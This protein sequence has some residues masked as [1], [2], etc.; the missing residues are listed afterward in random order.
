MVWS[1]DIEYKLSRQEKFGVTTKSIHKLIMI[2]PIEEQ[3]LKYDMKHEAAE[4][5]N[6]YRSM[7]SKMCKS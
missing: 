1:A 5:D 2:I 7:P 4:E 6:G 3:K